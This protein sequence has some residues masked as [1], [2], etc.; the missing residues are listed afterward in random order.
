MK[1]G[2]SARKPSVAKKRTAPKSVDDYLTAIPD[3]SRSNFDKLRSAVRSVVPA[4]AT[5]LISYGIPA[6]KDKKLLVWFAAF[7]QH[8]SLFPTPSVIEEC[9]E[10]LE[11]FTISKGTVQFPNDKP[12]PIALV[13]R[14][15]KARVA[16]Y[17]ATGR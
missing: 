6:F 8:C 15:V 10:E 4:E 2:I 5:E 12:L 7:A 16:K 1:K 17:K 14:L 3:G 9:R 13:K 11:D